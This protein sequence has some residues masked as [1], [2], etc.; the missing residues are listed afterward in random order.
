MRAVRQA[1]LSP[2]LA[3][4]GLGIDSLTDARGGGL[5]GGE[6]RRVALAWPE[7][8][9]DDLGRAVRAAGLAPAL[10]QRGLGI[11]SVID[12]RG[13][14]LSG[15]EIRRVALARALLKPSAVLLLD[16]PTAHLDMAAEIAL[17][18]TIR[19]ACRGRTTLI[20][21]HSA[22]LAAIADQ[23]VTLEPLA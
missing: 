21:T 11:D 16:E 4:R 20:A 23:I 1:G 7:A 15:G 3:R 22:R 2:A 18:A 19:A 9:T 14:G 10:A 13:G 6:I 12:A 5:S 17:I 8:G